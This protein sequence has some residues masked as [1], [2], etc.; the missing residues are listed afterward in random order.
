MMF[1]VLIFIFFSGTQLFVLAQHGHSYGP[2]SES[3]GL[4][5]MFRQ[6]YGGSKLREFIHMFAMEP[7]PDMIVGTEAGPVTSTPDGTYE[8]TFVTAPMILANGHVVNKWLPI[9][10]PH[11]HIA[12]NGF[13]AEVVKSGPN[14]ELP[15]PT[16]CCGGDSHVASREEVYMHHWTVNKYQLPAALFKEMVKNGGFDYELTTRKMSG[17]LE[18]LGGAGLNSG[19]N[20]PCWDSSLHLYFGIGNEVRTLGTEGQ[21][22]Y[23]FPDPYGI[24]FDSE[25]MRRK[26]EF[27]VLNTHLIDI[28]EVRD[29]RACTECK[30]SELGTHGAHGLENITTGG[31]SCCHSTDFDG[32]ICKLK[33]DETVIRNQTYSIRY[34]IK[35]RDFNPLTTLPLEVLSFDVTDN[36]TKWGDL[37]RI[38]GGFKESHEAMKNDPTTLARVNDPRSGDFT[39]RRACHIEW[40]V[41]SCKTG[42]SCIETLR[43]SWEVPWPLDIV[44]VR[45]HFHA[46]GINMTTSTDGFQCVGDSTY[47]D[48]DNIVD[49]STCTIDYHGD[50]NQGMHLEPGQKLYVESV[51][52]QDDLPHYGVMGMSFV[53]AHIPRQAYLHI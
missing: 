34:T 20:G 23:S 48:N 15:P 27:M 40:Y 16:P 30:C 29:K 35:W 39:G 32:G 31:L 26:G 18:F 25:M 53:Y 33:T 19:A 12:V 22:P 46:G 24:E 52:R 41:P 50:A 7:I 4:S 44:F 47:D 2:G 3:S 8:Q 1:R 13:A 45:N 37:P 5:A 21:F 11:G 43:N 42:D 28:R 14:G 36:N 38:P 17:L 51:Y 9:D 10:W 49:I 6:I